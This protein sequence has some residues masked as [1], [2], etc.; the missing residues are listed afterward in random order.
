MRR[1]LFLCNTK[2]HVWNGI[3]HTNNK[4]YS[5]GTYR[6]L[7]PMDFIFFIYSYIFLCIQCVFISRFCS[8]ASEF[9]SFYCCFHL[10]ITFLQHFFLCLSS[11]F[12]F[13]FFSYKNLKHKRKKCGLFVYVCGLFRIVR[14]LQY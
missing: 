3:H 11:F 1:F 13:L 7:L 12:V 10:H 8:V 4:N 9:E 2:M 6:L 14:E 5:V